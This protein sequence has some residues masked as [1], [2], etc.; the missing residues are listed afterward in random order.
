MHPF[1]AVKLVEQ[2]E[3][4]TA[5]ELAGF[6]DVLIETHERMVSGGV[7][8]KTLL[9]LALVKLLGTRTRESANGHQ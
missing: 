4:F 7:P 1:R 6:L 3:R 2:A 5:A 8:G 9:D